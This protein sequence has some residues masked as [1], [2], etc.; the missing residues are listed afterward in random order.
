M[1]SACR[2]EPQGEQ[3]SLEIVAISIDQTGRSAVEGFLQR[4]GVTGL[5]PFLDPLGR[6]A[7]SVGSDAPTPFVLRG[8][9]ISYIIDRAG[10]LSGYIT[11]GVEWTSR[12]GRA[13][14]E[15]YAHG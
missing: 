13:F 12:Q 4:L 3:Q 10:R 6:I 5:R 7:K 14:L 15:Y 8:I 11:G 1:V 9:P 2:R